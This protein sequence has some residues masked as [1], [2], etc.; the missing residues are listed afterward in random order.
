[1]AEEVKTKKKTVVKVEAQGTAAA[2]KK[3]EASGNAG[4]KRAAAIVLWVL[5]IACEIVGILALVGKI[6]ITFMS[7]LT[8]IIALLVLDL[9][10]VI[11]GSQFWKKANHIDPASKKNK[12]KFFLWNN[13]GVIVCIVAFLPYIILLLR[14]K[15]LDP[16]TRKIAV[17]AAIAALLIGGACSVDYNPVSQEEKEAAEQV[18]TGDVFWTQ[19]GKV[20]HTHEDCQALNGSDSLYTGTVDAAIEKNKTRLCSFCARKD[21]ITNVVTDNKT[22]DEE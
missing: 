6:S 19:F 9:I 11:V 15:K 20:Y 10:F 16:K 22:V 1:M 12:V 14:D 4:G 17:V 18:I 7:T 8:F 21:D 3:V 5:A 2:A 13:M